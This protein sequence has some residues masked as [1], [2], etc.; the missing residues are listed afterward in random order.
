MAR[1]VRPQLVN[2]RWLQ[3]ERVYP[4]QAVFLL[5]YGLYRHRA[6]PVA[7]DACDAPGAQPVPHLSPGNV[8]LACSELSKLLLIHY[9]SSD[10]ARSFLDYL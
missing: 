7:S 8:G 3:I 6:Q 1:F 10:W 5:S 2:I 4:G 9:L